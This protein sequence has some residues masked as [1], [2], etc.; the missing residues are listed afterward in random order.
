MEEPALSSCL[1]KGDAHCHLVNM[2][3]VGILKE[4][5]HI[6]N[7]FKGVSCC[8]SYLFIEDFMSCSFILVFVCTVESLMLNYIYSTTERKSDRKEG[9]QR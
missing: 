7:H 3:L 8:S 9:S 6:H 5:C 1:C 2:E 4:S